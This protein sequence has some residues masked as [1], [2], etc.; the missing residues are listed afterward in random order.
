MGVRKKQELELEI[1]KIAYGGLGVARVDGFVV[2]VRNVLPGQR[3]L[4]RI[5]RKRSSFAEATCVSVIKDSPWK[6]E[7]KCSHF[8]TCGGCSWQNLDYEKQLEIKT[9]QVKESLSHIGKISDV[10]FLPTVPSPSIYHYRNKLEFTFGPRRWIL[11]SEINSDK[12]IKP[13]D[14][15]LGFHVKDHWKKVVDIDECWL[16]SPRTN[17]IVA[18]VKEVASE[19]GLRPYDT[20]D[21]NGF[22]RFLVVRHGKTNGDFMVNLITTSPVSEEHKNAISRIAE[23][24]RSK[25]SFVSSFVY[26]VSDKKAQIAYGDTTQVVYGPGVIKEKLGNVTYSFSVNSFFQTNTLGTKKLYDEIVNFLDPSGDETVWDLY[27]GAGTISVYVANKVKRVI[28]V[29]LLPEA[30]KDA[31]NNCRENGISNC[32]FVDG[33]LKEIARRFDELAAKYGK[34]GVIITDPPR[35]GMH[36]DVIKGILSLEPQKIIAVSCNPTTFARDAKL[37]SEKYTLS[38]IRVFDLFPHT[39]HM[40]T[41]ALLDR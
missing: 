7:P 4:A 27:C 9:G 14:F 16:Q 32:V 10:R 34:P 13:K 24:L 33:D 15:A 19:S 20:L 29:E 18:V 8:G 36:K 2:F 23:E 31:E 37:L 40:E 22:W 38:K 5:V 30:I 28:G 3:I 17:E 41:V 1:E 6:V 26:S 12:I 35:A 11:P 39:T 25:C 21:H